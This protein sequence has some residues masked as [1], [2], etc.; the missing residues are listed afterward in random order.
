MSLIV[1]AI[2]LIHQRKYTVNLQ[3][4]FKGNHFEI[5]IHRCGNEGGRCYAYPKG[6]DDQ[7]DNQRQD[8]D[9][10]QLDYKP[11]GK[12]EPG[13]PKDLPGMEQFKIK[14]EFLAKTAFGNDRQFGG[15]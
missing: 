14:T 15:K 8:K 13:G 2:L 12:K 9:K 4:E 5:G 1:L 3:K 6:I 7:Q 10:D 11:Q